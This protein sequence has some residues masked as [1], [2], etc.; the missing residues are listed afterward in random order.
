LFKNNDEIKI[1]NLLIE[2]SE[3]QKIKRISIHINKDES[4][5]TLYKFIPDLTKKNLFIL[6]KA[7]EKSD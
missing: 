1:S 3:F 5:F 4:S 2:D 7:V 6:E